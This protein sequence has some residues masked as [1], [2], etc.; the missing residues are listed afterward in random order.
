MKDVKE[1]AEKLLELEK[2]LKE[3][4]T[5]LVE[6]LKQIEKVQKDREK[7]DQ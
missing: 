6:F 1:I 4:E 2:A 7:K 5:R 3:I